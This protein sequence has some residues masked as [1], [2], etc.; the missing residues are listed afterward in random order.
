MYPFP[1]IDMDYQHFS[2]Y[3]ANLLINICSPPKFDSG[4]HQVPLISEKTIEEAKNM[5]IV[6]KS[7]RI[8]DI[9]RTNLMNINVRFASP[10]SRWVNISK[11]EPKAVSR[12]VNHN[13][14]HLYNQPSFLNNSKGIKGHNIRH[15]SSSINKYITER[16]NVTKKPP[17]ESGISSILSKA[18]GWT[19]NS[20]DLCSLNRLVAKEESF[21]HLSGYYDN[22]KEIE[23]D[24][25]KQP[26]SEIQ[27]APEKC[28]FPL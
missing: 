18:E 25:N 9:K 21:D 27:E 8:Q 6:T 19:D 11:L 5:D 15:A 17:M 24:L 16:A 14:S 3:F 12:M 13:A 7:T 4:K 28:I 2:T 20:R 23:I 1:D 26:I 22:L 10:D